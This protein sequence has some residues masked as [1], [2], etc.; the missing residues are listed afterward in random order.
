MGIFSRKQKSPRESGILESQSTT[1]FGSSTFRGLANNR[2]SA[3][4][5]LTPNT[6]L[7]PMPSFKIPKIDLPRPPDPQ[8]D[9]A[10][11]LRSLTAVRE[12]AKALMERAQENQLVHFDVDMNKFPDVVTFVS[13]LIKRD[14]EA[15]FH[16]I[17]SHGRYQHFCVGGRDR[18]VELLNSWPE[19]VD[20][21]ERCRRLIDLFLISVLLDAGAGTSWTY[22]SAENGKTYR[23][24]EGIAVASLEMFKSGI[25]SASPT[26]KHQVDKRALGALTVAKLASGMQADPDNELVGLEG[27]TEVLVKLSEALDEHPEFFGA[28]GRPG[29]MID[30]LLSHPA[31][32]ASSILII[33]LP[34]LWNLLMDGL[35]SIWPS[36]TAINGVQLGDAWSCE[37]LP[38]GSNQWESILPFH[39]LTQW[40]AYSLMQ[41]MQSLLNM[42][43]AGTELLTGLPEYRNGG[44]FVDL[45][46]LTLRE[47]DMARGL[48]NYGAYCKHSGIKAIE[49][50]PMFDA[51]DDV[52]VEWRGLTV[53]LLDKLLEDVNVALAAELDGH[54]MTLAQLLEAGSWKGGREIAEINRPNT[55]EAPILVDSDGTVV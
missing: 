53:A 40:L 9:P 45:G 50:A 6:P 54:E 13:G 12:R 49:V 10:G 41:P 34:V 27:R 47:E 37:A 23:R 51:S 55:K 17:P 46:V 8:L 35:S 31:T 5:M 42:H 38:T 24:S 28:D 16:D 39:N 18:I 21:A 29:N 43:F 32:Q 48:A 2:V 4:S 7:S 26:N 33:P 30:Y 22:K 52:I 14:H 19:T 15:P 44:L 1:S 36:R 3:G 11:Y 25:F 20:N